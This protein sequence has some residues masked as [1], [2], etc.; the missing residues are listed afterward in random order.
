MS[1][2]ATRQD[3]PVDTLRYGWQL[4]SDVHDSLPPGFLP[5]LY[6]AIAGLVVMGCIWLVQA[7]QANKQRKAA[8]KQAAARRK[9]TQARKRRPT[10]Q[11]RRQHV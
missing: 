5:Y 2:G 7:H 1:A 11:K 4:L 6:T 3:D 10:Q 8:Q 9:K